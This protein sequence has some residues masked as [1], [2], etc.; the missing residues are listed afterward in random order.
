MSDEDVS[1]LI[2]VTNDLAGIN[3][4][5]KCRRTEYIIWRSVISLY[6]RRNGMPYHG[7]GNILKR[8]HDTVFLAV[9][10]AKFY[11]SKP[12]MYVTF[13]EAYKDFQKAIKDAGGL[14][15]K[16]IEGRTRWGH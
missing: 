8:G 9:K 15:F 12:S 11:L 5:A 2:R 10:N 14:E 3:V 4:I 7:I 6:L 13:N 16:T 1:K